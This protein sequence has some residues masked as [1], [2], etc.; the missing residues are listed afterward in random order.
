ME[1]PVNLMHASFSQLEMSFG[2]YSYLKEKQGKEPSEPIFKFREFIFQIQHVNDDAAAIVF[3]NTD[4]A[5]D[6]VD[7][8]DAFTLHT[9]NRQVRKRREEFVIVWLHSYELKY[10]GVT[11]WKLTKQ[12]QQSIMSVGVGNEME[13]ITIGVEESSSEDDYTPGTILSMFIN[14]RLLILV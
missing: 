5:G 9:G 8:P 11:I 13:K 6:T 2:S 1:Y 7:I 14:P 10:N 3:L 12:K 4:V